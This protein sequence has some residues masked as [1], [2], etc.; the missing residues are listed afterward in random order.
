MTTPAFTPGP[1]GVRFGYLVESPT[2]PVAETQREADADLIAAAPDL[3]AALDGMRQIESSM[4]ACPY[5]ANVLHVGTFPNPHDSDCPFTKARAALAKA[6]G[7]D[8]T[9]HSQPE[10]S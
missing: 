6:R 9:L 10:E 4:E 3:Y 8:G 1:W 7:Q 5:C 2:E